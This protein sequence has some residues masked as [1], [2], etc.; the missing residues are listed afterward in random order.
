MKTIITRITV[1]C[2]IFLFQSFLKAQNDEDY[3]YRGGNAD[4][5][6]NEILENA[7]CATPFHYYA[8]LGGNADGFALE[9]IADNANCSTPFHQFAY[10][11]GNADGAST[12][13]VANNVCATPYHFFAYFSGNSD[14][15]AMGKTADTCP[16][17]APVTDFIADQTTT[18]V[19][20]TV[21][22]TDTSTNKP[23]GWTWTFQGGTPATAST[24]KVDV[25]YNTPGVYQVKLVAAN[26]IGNDTK[27]KMGYITVVT[28]CAT[29][30]TTAVTKTK[31]QVYPNPTKSMLYLKSPQNVLN[32]EIYDA[33]GRKVMESKPNQK[34]AS[35][36][37][38]RLS[39]GMYMMKTR[40]IDGEEVYKI[41]KK[42]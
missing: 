40:T 13:T 16:I 4:G 31:M 29:L 41:I 17:I 42:D 19:G 14:G 12:E 6:A 22:F 26:Y 3:A 32:I 36:N 7:T 23:T 1:L 25:V 18:C 39:A 20:R 30:I 8:Y 34:D 11:G 9:T 37:M 28:D 27:I 21:K 35:I 10:F 2:L 5:F 15:F 38:E 33:T 24:K